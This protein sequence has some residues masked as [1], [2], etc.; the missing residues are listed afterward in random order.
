MNKVE[1]LQNDIAENE[2]ILISGYPNIFYYSGFTSE[3]AYLLIS[4]DEKY[5][6]TDSRYF[7]Q[8]KYQA[9]N[10]ALYDITKDLN[11]LIL[12]IPQKNIWYEEEFL[13]AKEYNKL[14][15]TGKDFLPKQTE[16]SKYRQIKSSDEI[17]KIQNA[18]ELGCEA[19]LDTIKYIKAGVSEKE[20]AFRLE[21]YMRKN[22]AS[23]LSFDT[24]VASGK[25]SAMPHGVASDRIIENGDLVTVDFGCV[26]DGYCSDMTRTV[27]VGK[28]SDKAKEIYDT[29][30]LA[31]TSAISAISVDSK[32]SDID[33]V[34]RDI[35]SDAGYGENFGHALGHGVGIE[36]H[37]NPC[38]SSK[39]IGTVENGNVI[40]VEPGIYIEDFGGVRIE[41]LVAIIDG[42]CEILSKIS[43]DLIIL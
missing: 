11:E 38:F 35:I 9:E 12:S 10:F 2:A 24:I 27:G 40:S 15:K 18:E 43:K 16:I 39:S 42:K 26:L 20:I 23:G 6:I 5:I 19:F 37:E 29:V 34:A 30:L 3:D 28:L 21:M 7:T 17:K 33:K 31:Q 36:I 41:D 25:R 13:T 1:K 8:A 4:Q 32:L 22:G 14:L